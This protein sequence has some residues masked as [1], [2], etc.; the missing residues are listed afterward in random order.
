MSPLSIYPLPGIYQYTYSTFVDR[1]QQICIH[2]LTPNQQ[3][4]FVSYPGQRN[5]K[6]AQ[7]VDI[8]W[9]K[10]VE[11]VKLEGQP[12]LMHFLDVILPQWLNDLPTKVIPLDSLA[13]ECIQYGINALSIAFG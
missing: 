7:L 6:A 5:R 2:F 11:L 9:F 8:N 10:L 4:A 12:Q 3:Q 13:A 1:P